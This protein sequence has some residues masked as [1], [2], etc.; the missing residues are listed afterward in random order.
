MSLLQDQFDF[1]KEFIAHC[2]ANVNDFNCIFTHKALYIL[3]EKLADRAFS[4][5]SLTIDMQFPII[6]KK[7]VDLIQ[8]TT[9]SSPW[10]NNY[11]KKYGLNLKKI[12][13]NM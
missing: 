13:T 6:S 10:F 11:C 1:L 12:V 4:G 8:G 9:M 3:E 7:I 5:Y 2:I